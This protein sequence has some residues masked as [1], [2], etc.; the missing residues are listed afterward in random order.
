MSVVQLLEIGSVPDCIT[1]GEICGMCVR[2]GI[3]PAGF[4]FDNGR[5][6]V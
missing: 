6:T 4:V 5:L 3:A 1:K 2:S